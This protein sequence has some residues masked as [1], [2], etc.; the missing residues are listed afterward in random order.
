MS[1]SR[2]Q[3]D[4]CGS[5]SFGGSGLFC[6]SGVSLSVPLSCD[7]GSSDGPRSLYSGK[8]FKCR[9][10]LLYSP[11]GVATLYDLGATYSF[12]TPLFRRS[13]IHTESPGTKGPNVFARCR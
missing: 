8:T 7:I 12:T 11:A 4:L 3:E 9:R 1:D 10:F 2:G 6:D 5:Q 13:A